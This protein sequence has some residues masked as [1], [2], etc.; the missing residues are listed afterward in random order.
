MECIGK[1]GMGMVFRASDTRLRAQRAIKLLRLPDSLTHKQAEGLRNRLIQEAQAAQA[2]A[3]RTHHVVRVFDVGLYQ[4]DP[5]LVMEYLAGST[6][7]DCI[8]NGPLEPN[9]A[10][11]MAYRSSKP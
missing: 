4:E 1:G 11:D 5:Y 6:L 7:A 8:D 2:L 3:E 9:V 10:C